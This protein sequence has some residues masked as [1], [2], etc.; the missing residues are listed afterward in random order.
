MKRT[1]L[2]AFIAIGLACVAACERSSP[3]TQAPD[4]TGRN[5]VD[6]GSNTKTPPDQ[7]ENKDDVRIT[8][9]IRKAVT[10]DSSLS[11]NAHNCKIVT[12]GGVVTLRGVVESQAEKDSIESKA[13]SVAGV[14]R[15]DNQLEIKPG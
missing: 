12:Q 1:T 15:V 6:R 3:Q 2:S 7:N 14:S 10:D 4:N 13:K 9:D 5:V 8:A 11:V